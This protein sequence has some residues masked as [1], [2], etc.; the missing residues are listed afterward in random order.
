MH[1]NY[2]V[3]CYNYKSN[4]SYSVRAVRGGQ[5]GSFGITVS[6]PSGSATT[7]A[8]GTVTFTVKLNTQPTANVTIG[9]SSSDTTE[10]T[11]SPS[12]II[13]TTANWNTPQTVT[14]TRVDDSIV[15]GNIAY[16][17][18]TAAA[19]STDANYNGLNASDVSLTNNDN[20]TTALLVP[21]PDTGQTR[22][23]NDSV[24]IP[25]PAEGQA[26]YGQDANY[27]INPPSYTKLDADGNDLP[28]NA[29]E[30]VMVR[31]KLL[32]LYGK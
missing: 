9:L 1:F 13:F 14:V 3:D 28:D 5:S 4:Y 6:T 2:G 32:A 8:G 24:E 15:D 12:L 22:C 26:F 23:Y 16:T 25:C 7:E 11:V 10:G 18:V 29:T 17:I 21:V 31:D 30:W 19:T 20:D 27:T